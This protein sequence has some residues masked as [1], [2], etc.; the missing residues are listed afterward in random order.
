MFMVNK[1]SRALIYKSCNKYFWRGKKKKERE[2]FTNF[3]KTKV[4]F[5]RHIT[6]THTHT[7]T[8][9]QY[10]GGFYTSYLGH[11]LSTTPLHP[12]KKGTTKKKVPILPSP[13]NLENPPFTPDVQSICTMVAYY[14]QPHKACS[15]V[16]SSVTPLAWQQADLQDFSK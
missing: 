10:F 14:H 5:A 13:H 3:Q 7:H 15:D 9:T 6:N 8:P 12:I 4:S 1:L 2:E 16:T 11:K